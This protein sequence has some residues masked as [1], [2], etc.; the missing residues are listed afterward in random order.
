MKKRS[1]LK[2]RL[3]SIVMSAAFILT[4]MPTGFFTVETKAAESDRP[5]GPEDGQPAARDRC[6]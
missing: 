4:G 3:L 1:C 6:R 2:T 5:A